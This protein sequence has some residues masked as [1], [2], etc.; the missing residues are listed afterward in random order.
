VT[1]VVASPTDPQVRGT[2]WRLCE[3]KRCTRSHV[4]IAV[5]GDGFA[6]R[7]VVA[8]HGDGWVQLTA[9]DAGTFLVEGAGR[10][11]F[12][13]R[14]D[15]TRIPVGDPGPRAALRPGELLTHPTT[16]GT[17]W[18]GVD[19]ATGVAHLLPAAVDGLP[20]VS[21][22]STGRLEAVRYAASGA[23]SAY[24]WSDDGGIGW[25]THPVPGRAGSLLQPVPSALPGTAAVLQ[26][27]DGATLFPFVAVHRSTRDGASWEG[28]PQ[29]RAPMAFVASS[30]VLPDGR[31]LVDVDGWGDDRAGKPAHPKGPYVSDGDDWTSFTRVL[32]DA[33]GSPDVSAAERETLAGQDYLMVVGTSVAPGRA[34]VYVA[35]QG[36]T[37]TVYAVDG[38]TLAWTPVRV[39]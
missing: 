38:E 5:T 3:P 33:A 37:G 1:E 11:P 10:R 14:P 30:V 7:A 24:L 8:V 26:G 21:A 17:R 23:S 36:E 25:R 9:T 35:P 32:P 28:I 12:L 29:S 6:T 2:V 13:L 4:A 27:G 15:G 16:D 22:D 39:R 34:T 18:T 31:L 20:E 19:P